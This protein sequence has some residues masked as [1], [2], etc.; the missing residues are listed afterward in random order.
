[1][2]IEDHAFL[3]LFAQDVRRQILDQAEILNLPDKHTIF[4]EDDQPDALYLVLSGEVAIVKPLPGSAYQTITVIAANEYFG[5]Y[6]V[7]DGLARSATAIT[8]G[9]AEV[10]RFRSEAIMQ[11]LNEA[12]G[13]TILDLARNLIDN[14]RKSNERYVRDIVHKTKLTSLGELLNTILHDL[15]NPFTVIS[16][17]SSAIPRVKNPERVNEL[18]RL[19]DGQIERM[20]IMTDEIL[21]YARGVAKMKLVPTPISQILSRFEFLNRDYL[22]HSNVELV[23]IGVDTVIEADVN[24]VLR[25]LQNL[26]NNATEMFGNKGGHIVIMAR[27]V[28]NGL[29]VS[30]Q[31]D[32][33]GVP[34]V[35]RSHLFEPFA[36]HGKEKGIGL[37]LAITKSLVE[38]HNGRITVETTTGAGT[39]FHIFFPIPKPQ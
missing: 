34:E 33:P 17:A 11:I 29:E 16:L 8:R 37:G 36:T 1:M 19:I 24:K 4:R 39:T 23:V 18:C 6:G 9:P 12:P 7:L 20:K 5:E 27:D 15:R 22:A 26:V 3:Q 30:V 38:S 21:E 32:G 35:I 31:D 10:A 28:E 25:I 13:H 2:K 14:V